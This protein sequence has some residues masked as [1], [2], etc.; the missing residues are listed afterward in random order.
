MKSGFCRQFA[1]MPVLKGP[2]FVIFLGT[3]LNGIS[4]LVNTP[5]VRYSSCVLTVLQRPDS[6]PNALAVNSSIDND[7]FPPYGNLRCKCC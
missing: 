7:A 3:M 2:W 6:L 5:D 1:R 4:S